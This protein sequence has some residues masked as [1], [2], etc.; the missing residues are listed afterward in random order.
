M[1]QA[2]ISY[3]SSKDG[4]TIA[5]WFNV[6][7]LEQLKETL[8]PQKFDEYAYRGELFF[9]VNDKTLCDKYGHGNIYI[10]YGDFHMQGIV[11]KGTF[12]TWDEF[13]AFAR[14]LN[15]AGERLA[16]IKKETE[17]KTLKI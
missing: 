15:K 10:R 1:K 13:Y 14:I 6:L 3:R 17:L 4:A 5:G 16:E 9:L 8:G 11:Q 7:T 2:E 12:L